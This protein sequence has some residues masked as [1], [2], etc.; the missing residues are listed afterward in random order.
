MNWFGGL[1]FTHL[2]DTV[3]KY[4]IRVSISEIEWVDGLR[5]T[6]GFRSLL[7][8]SIED[9]FNIPAHLKD[10]QGMSVYFALEFFRPNAGPSIFIFPV[11]EKDHE[12][13]I[14]FNPAMKVI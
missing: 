13:R 11:P 14:E 12:V 1:R 6:K 8:L 4:S 5:T 3:D 7:Q 10:M 2:Q 9:Y